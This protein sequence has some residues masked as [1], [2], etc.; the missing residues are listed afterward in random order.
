MVLS[1][2]NINNFRKG[3][4]NMKN[5]N[6]YIMSIQP[7]FSQDYSIPSVCAWYLHAAPSFNEKRQEKYK[8]MS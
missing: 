6:Q 8:N 7:L 2:R 5:F 3:Y 1:I 4:Y